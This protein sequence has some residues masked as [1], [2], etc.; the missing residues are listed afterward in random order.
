M[1]REEHDVTKLGVR[2]SGDGE[3]SQIPGLSETGEA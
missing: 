2:M 3:G 1:P